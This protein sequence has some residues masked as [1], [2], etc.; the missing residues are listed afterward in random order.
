MRR[1]DP[2]STSS[3]AGNTKPMVVRKKGEDLF[4][5]DVPNGRNGP[6]YR[7]LHKCT[8]AEAHLLEIKITKQLGRPARDRHRIKDIAEYYLEYVHH[9]QA[10]RTYK[11]KKRILFGKLLGYF[12]GMR[13]DFLSK[14]IIEAYKTK[15]LDE[16]QAAEKTQKEKSGK[17]IKKDKGRRQVN[18]ELLCLGNMWTWAYDSGYCTEEP[19]RIT[20]LPYKRPLPETLSRSDVDRILESASRFHRAM[21]LCMYAAG[22]R[23]NEVFDLRITDAHLN[24]GYLRVRGKGNKTRL[25]PM[26]PRLEEALRGQVACRALIGAELLFPSPTTGKKYNNIKTAL[27]SAVK[28]SGIN[29]TVTPHML[30]HSFATHLLEQGKDLRTIQELLGHEEISTTQIYTHIALDRKRDAVSGM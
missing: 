25:V 18:I 12:G 27:K 22:L 6:R 9:H 8:E 19:A 16:I 17:P 28:R 26:A 11:E 5:I 21:I 2:S 15:R 4:E 3:N 23:M 10:E 13:F 1:F 7:R 24:S 30:R 14:P 29:K 20:K